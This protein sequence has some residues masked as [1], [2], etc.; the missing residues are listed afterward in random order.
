M[1]QRIYSIVLWFIVG[2][3]VLVWLPTMAVLF[4]LTVPFDPGRYAVGRWFRVA[5]MMCVKVN[6]IWH[7]RWTGQ[8]PADP[9]RPYIVVSN[10]ESFTDILLISHVPWEMKWLS[11]ASLFRIPVM[12]W[13]MRMAGDIE[14]HRGDLESRS[15]ALYGIRDRLRK[16]VSVMIFPEGTRSR[17]G[18][19]LPFRNGAFKVAVDTGTPILPLALAGTSTAL[20]K[21]TFL[22]GRARA[23]VRVLEPVETAGLGPGDVPALRDRVRRMIEE[24]RADI[25][26]EL[27]IEG[28]NG[29]EKTVAR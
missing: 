8:R 11:K 6:P 23:C 5:A 22:M 21:G 17:T 29:G 20:A 10:H 2:L 9:R 12:G 24:A 4:V 25:R 1:L 16:R 28:E 26:R 18:E 15:G 14:V 27:G 7:F 19:M 13:E 3:I